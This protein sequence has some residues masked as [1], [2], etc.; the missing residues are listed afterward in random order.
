VQG[1]TQRNQYAPAAPLPVATDSPPTMRIGLVYDCLYPHTV[2]GA[3]RWLR[4]LAERLAAEGHD[5]TY[6]TLRQWP[7]GEPPQVPGVK[8][9]AVGPAMALYT[10]GGRRRILPPIVF[11]LGVFAHLLRHWRSYDVVHTGAFPYFSLLAAAAVRPLGR[12]R[13]VVEWYEVWTRAYWNEYLGR[14]GGL[15][16][17]SI[18]RLCLKIPQHAFCL[19]QLHAERLRQEGFRGEVEVVGGLY[20]G[21]LEVRPVVDGA[22][23][24]VV[25][26]GRHIPEK[27]VLTL[28]PAIARARESVPEL[29]CQ[30]FGDGP[31]RAELLRLIDQL[32]LGGVVEAPGFVDMQLVDDAL[33]SALCMVLPSRREGYGMIV[34]EAAAKGTPSVLVADPD[35]AATELIEPGVNGFVAE[36]TDPEAL[37]DAIVRVYEAGRALRESTTAWFTSNAER[38][39]LPNTLDSVAVAYEA[40]ASS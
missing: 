6:L 39:S 8:V 33:R 38:L 25:F 35:N 27:R 17:W 30:I 26:A 23:P 18:Q 1:A 19:S 20:A 14:V 16:G 28:V 4:S 3:E 37:A 36:S 15:I 22:P 29:R 5:V 12:F 24:T 7:R 9:V 10:D 32:A 40:R 13:F 31:D 21:S 11:G 2:G 34:V